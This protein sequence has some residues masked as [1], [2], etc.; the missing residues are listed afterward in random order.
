MAGYFERSETL[1]TAHVEGCRRFCSEL[2]VCY[3]SLDIINIIIARKVINNVACNMH[4]VK[5][6]RIQ[7]LRRKPEQEEPLGRFGRIILCQCLKEI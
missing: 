6:K 1:R 2:H 7:S 3:S 5:K 4:I